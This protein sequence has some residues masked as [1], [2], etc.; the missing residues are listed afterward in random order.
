MLRHIRALNQAVK[1]TVNVRKG[2]LKR[3]SSFP[4]EESQVSLLW[5]E[6]P[7][8]PGPFLP[9]TLPCLAL[10]APATPDKWV[11]VPPMPCRFLLV[12]IF[13]TCLHWRAPSYLPREHLRPLQ[14]QDLSWVVCA[15]VAPS[16][17]SLP[18]M[19]LCHLLSLLCCR[20]S[21]H[22]AFIACRY[23]TV[24][25]RRLQRG[26]T[27]GAWGAQAVQRPT[28]GFSSAHELTVSRV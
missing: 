11:I 1:E 27:Q 13:S 21:T 9:P 20:G 22:G 10:C 19:A 12:L 14:C 17:L 25:C 8:W 6:R 24:S 18:P 15:S 2:L 4:V 3:G 5:L 26:S 16:C 7:S 28:L 23:E